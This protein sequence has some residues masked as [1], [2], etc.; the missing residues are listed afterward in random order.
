[1]EDVV[2]KKR[3][4]ILS[5]E[6]DILFDDLDDS[7]SYLTFDETGTIVIRCDPYSDVEKQLYQQG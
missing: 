6:K 5:V 3:K 4:S 2:L 1:M 7:R